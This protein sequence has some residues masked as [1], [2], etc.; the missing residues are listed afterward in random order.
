M[1]ALAGCYTVII[2]LDTESEVDFLA[3]HWDPYVAAWKSSHTADD[4]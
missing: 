4:E 2:K 1:L 3:T